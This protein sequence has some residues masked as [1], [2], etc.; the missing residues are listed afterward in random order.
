MSQ[1]I[2]PTYQSSQAQYTQPPPYYEEI[3]SAPATHCDGI[4]CR[5]GR[6]FQIRTLMFCSPS[7]GNEFFHLQSGDDDYWPDDDSSDDDSS[8]EY[9]WS[10]DD[11]SDDEEIVDPEDDSSDEEEIVDPED[12][13]SDDEE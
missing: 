5:G 2:P 13:S 3:D 1:S 10:E 11:S 9:Y 12:D 4:G 7:C 6:G 8:D